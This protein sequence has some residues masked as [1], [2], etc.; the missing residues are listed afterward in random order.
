MNSTAYSLPNLT[1][2]SHYGFATLYQNN[3]TG[4]KSLHAT[5]YHKAGDI[6]SKFDAS[7][8]RTVPDK[9]TVQVNDYTHIILDPEFLQYI[10]HSCNPNVFFDTTRMELSCLKDI[11]PG[12]ELTFFYP[13]T[14]WS[15]ASPFNCFCGDNNC[16][17]KIQG[18]SFLPQ[19]VIH[20]YKFTDFIMDKL[21][22]PHLQKV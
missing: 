8:I 13:S 5:V 15:M 21:N 1:K 10:N 18:A 2:I 9:Y 4:E 22:I 16:L 12:D 17:H 11:A 7:E 6:F 19:E 14:E 20:H 3:I